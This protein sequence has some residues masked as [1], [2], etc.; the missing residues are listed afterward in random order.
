[1][2]RRGFSPPDPWLPP[3]GLFSSGDHQVQWA[4]VGKNMAHAPTFDAGWR[5][6]LPRGNCLLRNHVTA[7]VDGLK[8]RESDTRAGS[9][10]AGIERCSLGR[11]GLPGNGARMT[12]GTCTCCLDRPRARQGASR[13]QTLRLAHRSVCPPGWFGGEGADAP[14]ISMMQPIW[15]SVDGIV[16][17]RQ[18]QS[19]RSGIRPGDVLA[20]RYVLGSLEM[21]M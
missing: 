12:R 17:G 6:N 21:R 2:A 4:R 9:A 11:M 16:R 1:M 15:R 18:G 19:T 10:L 3:P 20:L 7:G 5:H 8:I 14:S 13:D